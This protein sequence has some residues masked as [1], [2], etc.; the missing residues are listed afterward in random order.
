MKNIYKA[1]QKVSCKKLNYKDFS[2]NG[3]RKYLYT[4]KSSFTSKGKYT[5]ERSHKIFFILFDKSPILFFIAV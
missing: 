2:M 4:K 3:W 1:K 5:M